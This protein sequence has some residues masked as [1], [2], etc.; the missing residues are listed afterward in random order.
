MTLWNLV[1]IIKAV[2]YMKEACSLLTCCTVNHVHNVAG[3][4]P[5]SHFADE[6]GGA[7]C[8]VSVISTGFRIA[9]KSSACIVSLASCPML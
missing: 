6:T 4:D 8:V 9:D 7:G 1:C 2:S 3:T 5:S